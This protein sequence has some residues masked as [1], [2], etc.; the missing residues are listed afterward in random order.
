M[1]LLSLLLLLVKAQEVV[2]L[3]GSSGTGNLGGGLHL[4]ERD[5]VRGLETRCLSTIGTSWSLMRPLSKQQSVQL[6]RRLQDAMVPVGFPSTLPPEYLQ[7]TILN[8]MQDS[9]SYLRGIMSMGAILRGLGVG[10]ATQTPAAATL[11]WILRD[12]AGMIGS[13]VL[14]SFKST[15]FGTNA[16]RWRLFADFINNLGLTL[17]LLAPTF[18][19]KGVFLALLSLASVFKALCG[20]AA[21]ATNAVFLDHWGAIHGNTADVAAKASAQH[22]ALSLICLSFSVPFIRFTGSLSLLQTWILY[23]SLTTLHM[24][25]NIKAMRLLA[26]RSINPTRLQLLVARFLQGAG[27]DGLSTAAIAKA[28]PL[29]FFSSASAA[30]TRG[31]VSYWGTLDTLLKLECTP[32]IM[33]KCLELYEASC[34]YFFVPTEAGGLVVCMRQHCTAEDQAKAVLESQMV[35]RYVKENSASV[36]MLSMLELLRDKHAE[37]KRRF[38]LFWAQLRDLGWDTVRIQLRPPNAVTIC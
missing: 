23:G 36:S 8:I 1:R 21:G 32:N 15:Q 6:R 11:L 20:V 31:G 25:L 37:A 29:F 13:L 28:E 19:N 12:G 30:S 7:Y 14:T 24:V 18:S 3:A 35:S 2:A 9:C 4:Q 22:T 33:A 10:D 26:L 5:A 17:E 38:P 27:V 16:K 34:G